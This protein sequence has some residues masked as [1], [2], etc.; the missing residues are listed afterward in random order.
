MAGR[1][2]SGE[3]CGRECA[4]VWR[5]LPTFVSVLNW[6]EM[7]VAV[8]LAGGVGSRLDSSH[9]KQ[10]F[11]VAGRTV[12]EHTI[13]VF[14]GNAGI[15]EIAVVVHPAY[16]TTV[17]ELV[18]KNG[19]RKVRKLLKGGSE[20]YYSSLAAIEAYDGQ[21]GVNLIF[22]DAV[23]P[24]VSNRVI[25]DTVRAL[26]RWKAVDVA[27]PAVDTIIST[28]GE[29][30][31]AI[32]DRSK[33]RRGQTPQGFR[34][35]T[36]REAYRR[37][38]RDPEFRSTDDCGVVLKY[39]PE[40]RIYVVRGE[41]SNMKL[42]YKEDT[43]L[44]DKL[45]QLRSFSLQGQRESFEELEGKVLAVFGGS[46]GIGAEVAALAREHGARVYCFSRSL[47]GVDIAAAEDVRRALQEV[48]EAEGRVDMVVNTAAVL[49]REPLMNMG[50][51]EMARMVQVNYMGMVHVAVESFPYLKESRGKLL[52][53]TSSSYTRGRAF[54]SL[55]SS[56]KAAV[57]NF[58]QAVAQEWEPWGIQV[59]CVNPERTKTPMR[60]RNFGAEDER[61]LLTAREVAVESLKTLLSDF[62]GQ[63]IDV[64][65]NK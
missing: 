39:L 16:M 53:Y 45:F 63:V 1:D 59:N 19:W 23:R 62:T 26:E 18:L 10:F 48:A 44:L 41:E 35:E 27:V 49:V 17:E 8:I 13:G 24:L 9:P 14:E 56:T 28:E 57:V 5:I 2:F 50:Y 3:F 54:Y 4:V 15:D 51:E 30:V 43:Y 33:L 32:P 65:L 37:A 55:Y 60:V 47:N 40:E 64:K 31:D 21:E 61:T 11:K 34:L 20:R 58:V 29:W 6:K 12:I 52:F 38:L 25:D 22:H 46:Y 36:I 42:T 7:N